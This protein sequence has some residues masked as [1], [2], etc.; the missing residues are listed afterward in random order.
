MVPPVDMWRRRGRQASTRAGDG[1]V[2]TC[3]CVEG[4]ECA[5]KDGGPLA[6]KLGL[7]VELPE[8][9]AVAEAK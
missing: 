1:N 3:S 2:R 5:E 8:D 7:P 4:D 6:G 9:K